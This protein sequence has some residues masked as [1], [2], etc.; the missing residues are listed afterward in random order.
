MTHSQPLDGNAIDADIEEGPDG[1]SEQGTEEQQ[2]RAGNQV[3]D[4]IA[5]SRRDRIASTTCEGEIPSVSSGS[6]DRWR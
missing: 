2:D 4:Q 5:S 3:R 6:P 1:A